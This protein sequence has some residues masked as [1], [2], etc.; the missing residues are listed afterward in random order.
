MAAWSSGTSPAGMVP[1][2]TDIDV[3]TDVLDKDLRI[4]ELALSSASVAAGQQ[5]TV[6]Y[7]AFNRSRMSITEDWRESV[8][9]RDP[10][11]A[12]P[13]VVIANLGTSHL[14]TAR[15]NL[16]VSHTVS[17]AYTI[18][19][20]TAPGTY[21]IF[22]RGDS[23]NAIPEANE[24]NNT[25]S[26][27]ITI[28][29]GK[30]LDVRNL[31]VTPATSS[32]GATVTVA[33]EVENV[34]GAAVTEDWKES[35]QLRDPNGVLTSLGSSHLHTDNLAP[36]G[37]H[38]YS[39]KVIIPVGTAAG[40]FNIVVKTDSLAAIAEG[41]ET[42]NEETAALALQAGTK[43][44]V[45]QNLAVS[46]N[47]V[48]SGGSLL[49]NY[50]IVNQGTITLTESFKENVILKAPGGAETLLGSSHLHTENLAPAGG[51]NASKSFTIPSG[52]AA[53]TYM[54]IV[55]GD[56]GGA[57]A[58]SDETNNDGTINVQIQ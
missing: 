32:P 18:P 50:R 49:V 10:N 9:L 37:V 16:G 41:N 46:P 13:N 55:R 6:S 17:Q 34:G 26:I 29:L 43:D 1:A 14:H 20:A 44:I 15:V 5:V 39:R 56:S 23:T 7:K 52:L 54:I 12:D 8:H 2:S 30:D 48:A 57:V 25:I 38:P 35:I 58:E 22:V 40:A 51:H 4:E 27:P 24:T 31:S 53:G 33:Y 21:Q 11:V 28:T 19:A 42:N 45:I 47:P 36:A 3:F